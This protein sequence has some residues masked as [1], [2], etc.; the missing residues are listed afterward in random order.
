MKQKVKFLVCGIAVIFLSGCGGM[1][2]RTNTKVP[3][4]TDYVAPTL[5][6]S[7]TLAIKNISTNVGDIVIGHWTGWTVYADLY[8]YT[9]TSIGILKNIL[10]EQNINVSSSAAKTLELSVYDAES[11]QGGWVFKASTSLRVKTGD[12]LV[13]EYLGEKRHGNGY[14]TTSAMERT[15]VICVQEMLKDQD[16][17]NY[18]EN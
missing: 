8:K 1:S 2:M 5:N 3:V 9:D 14:G 4:V 7:Q 18:L 11:I 16:I 10:A 13:K 12:G 17:I 15:L 6:V